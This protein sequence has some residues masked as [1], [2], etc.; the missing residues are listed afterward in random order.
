MVEK[1]WVSHNQVGGGATP[2]GRH[3]VK[4][5]FWEMVKLGLW[6]CAEGKICRRFGNMVLHTQ[7]SEV[8]FDV[9]QEL[10]ARRVPSAYAL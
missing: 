7:G 9:L 4:L 5:Y 1:D 2:S 3:P 8:S 10:L 6:L